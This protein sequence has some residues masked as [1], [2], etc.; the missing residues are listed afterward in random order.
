MNYKQAEYILMIIAEGG[1]TA[2]SKKLYISQPALSQIVKTVED[3]YKAPIFVRGTSPI[4]LT[5][6]GEKVVETARKH[7]LLDQNLQ[8]EIADINNELS[9]I[10]KFGMLKGQGH[11]DSNMNQ[12]ISFLI[13]VYIKEFPRITLKILEAG[14]LV[15]EKMLI[16]GNLDV[17]MVST[18]PVNS[19]LEYI[20]LKQDFIGVIA[21]KNSTFAKRHYN[22]I[23][24]DFRDASDKT[25]IAKCQGN[26]T[27]LMLDQ[28]C[29]SYGF[30]PKILFE[31][32]QFST[33][34]NIM[35]MC[36]CMMLSSFSS[37]EK[38]PL[39]KENANFFRIKGFEMS[40]DIYLCY[41]KNMYVPKYMQSWMDTIKNY[42]R[43]QR[44]CTDHLA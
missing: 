33:A 36:D 2:A 4:Q 40:S 16:D 8:N 10:F 38:N 7:I 20:L 24:I 11:P 21:G 29:A 3:E 23:E 35:C 25:F 18:H 26:Y 19:D 31:Y 27:R 30:L 5:Y 37:Y 12:T 6:I 42:Y 43:S 22:D 14:S 34:A 9:G 1:I 39:L 41:R 15:I 32:A 17:G 28:L 44:N 13:P